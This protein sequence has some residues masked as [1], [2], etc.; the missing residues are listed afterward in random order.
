ML[1]RR[2]LWPSQ[3]RA[4]ATAHNIQYHD[5]IPTAEIDVDETSVD[6]YAEYRLPKYKVTCPECEGEIK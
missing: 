1:I 5:G 3:A 2:G 4:V 6:R